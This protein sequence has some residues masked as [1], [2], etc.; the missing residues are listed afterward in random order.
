MIKN[1]RSRC[2]KWQTN[3]K[4]N[5]T[6]CQTSKEESFKYRFVG[7]YLKKTQ[8]AYS[9][10]ISKEKV[11]ASLRRTLLAH[12]KLGQDLFRIISVFGQ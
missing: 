7:K 10:N 12:L 6:H 2:K 9:G 5:G 8:L 11:E 1:K 4:V 3:F